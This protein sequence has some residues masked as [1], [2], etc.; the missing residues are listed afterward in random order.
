MRVPKQRWMARA[1]AAAAAALFAT[2]VALPQAHA[3][4]QEG[5]I[6]GKGVIT[7]DW[8][9]E[10]V[11]ST[12]SYNHSSAV[13]VWQAVLRADGY[14]TGADQ[15]CWFGQTTRAATIEWQRDR[16]LT[17]DGEVGPQT[18]G[19]ADNWLSLE[20]ENVIY[21]G[22][23]TN[24]TWGLTRD[25]TTGIYSYPKGPISYTSASVCDDSEASRQGARASS[26]TQW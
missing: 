13:A 21:D 17:A 9:D 5:Y 18:F 11:L 3:N 16:G 10:G 26:T 25:S 23:V 15:D 8:G 12:T 6:L 14:L 22:A 7:N 19:Y 4:V 2:A 20:G 24:L 1:G